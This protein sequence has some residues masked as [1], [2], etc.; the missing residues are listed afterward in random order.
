[1]Q[2]HHSPS[3]T[4]GLLRWGIKQIVFVLILVAALFLSAGQFAWQKAWIYLGLVVLTQLLTASLLIP[5]N[6]EL[7]VERSQLQEGVKGWD[8]GLAILMAYGSVLI[9]PAAGLQV[10]LEGIAP[11]SPLFLIL[12]LAAAGLGALL[13]LW[14][15][16]ANP[17]FSGMVR[18]QK[19]RGHVA[20]SSGPYQYIRHP[21]YL[22][23]LIFTLATPL[24][25]GSMWAFYPAVLVGGAT[26]L[27][28]ALE[29][30]TLQAELAGYYDY[31]RRVRYRLL[32]GIW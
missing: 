20:V 10:R 23:A 15:M 2:S 19:E 13:T 27:R 8:I 28:T 11:I 17:F 5:R 22:G 29:D 24:I 4:R 9:A 32:P 25:L 31:S 3:L 14:A 7:L 6:P 1:M 26:I 21:G 30:R 16:L 12:A 18:I